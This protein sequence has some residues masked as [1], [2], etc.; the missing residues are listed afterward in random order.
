MGAGGGG[1]FK[2]T[3]SAQKRALILGQKSLCWSLCGG[4]KVAVAQRRSVW[5]GRCRGVCVPSQSTDQHL[6]TQQKA[7]LTVTLTHAPTTQT[8]LC[9]A[10]I[11]GIQRPDVILHSQARPLVF[12]TSELENTCFSH[13]QLHPR[14]HTHSLQGVTVTHTGLL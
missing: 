12:Y 11:R 7:L 5:Q 6:L 3:S 1:G 14:T 9:F 2:D 13:V 8:A 4:W 10:S